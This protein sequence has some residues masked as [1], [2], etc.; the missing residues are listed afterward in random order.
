MLLS[1]VDSVFQPKP[2][3][4]EG[5]KSLGYGTVTDTFLDSTAEDE[6]FIS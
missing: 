6:E 5:V 2:Y 4:P 1:N 3:L